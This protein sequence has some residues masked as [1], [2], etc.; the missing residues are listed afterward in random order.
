VGLSLAH[1]RAHL[2]RA[3]LEGVAFALRHNIEA[4]RRGAVALDDRL[5]VVGGAA[6]SALWMQ[7]IADVT[8]FP[9]WTIEQ[10]VEAAMGAALLAGVGAGLVSDDDA[11]GG[12]VTLVERAR[13]D[14]DRANA[15]DARFAL[16]TTLYPALKPI[17][18]RLGTS[19]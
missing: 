12:W 5:I 7:I 16:Y 9:V 4:G 17:M 19:S 3:V 1:T 11:Q 10:D 8:G 15:Y 18:H 14:A 13:P 6:H 2:Y